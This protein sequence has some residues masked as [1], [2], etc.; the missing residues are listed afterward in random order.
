MPKKKLEHGMLL[1]G[2]Y[3]MD[4]LDWSPIKKLVPEALHDKLEECIENIED[5]LAGCDVSDQYEEKE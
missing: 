2:K 5:D 3:V 1:D 4:N